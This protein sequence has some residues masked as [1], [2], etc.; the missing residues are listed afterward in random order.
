MLGQTFTLSSG[1]GCKTRHLAL[2]DISILLQ[3][4]CLYRSDPSDPYCEPQVWNKVPQP[5]T[6]INTETRHATL[7]IKYWTSEAPKTQHLH[8][9]KTQHLHCTKTQHL[10]CTKTQHL[11][12][13]VEKLQVHVCL[14]CFKFRRSEDP[15]VL[16]WTRRR[17]AQNMGRFGPNMENIRNT[18]VIAYA[19]EKPFTVRVRAHMPS[20]AAKL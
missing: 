15:R 3:A 1:Q 8:C 5:S 17:F 7:L 11:H 2:L 14:I 13:T 6:R 20:S 9:T 19:L 18:P 10:H 16:R 12:C 4:L